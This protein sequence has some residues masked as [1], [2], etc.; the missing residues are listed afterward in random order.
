MCKCGGGQTPCI[1]KPQLTKKLLIFEIRG[2]IGVPESALHAF[3]G[4][5][6]NVFSLK[7][8]YKFYVIFYVSVFNT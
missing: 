1:G 4:Q 2:L 3:L 8:H 5:L 7:N 6:S